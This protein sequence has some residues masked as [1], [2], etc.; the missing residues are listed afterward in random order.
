MRKKSSFSPAIAAALALVVVAS[1]VTLGSLASFAKGP[2]DPAT[3]CL[4][5]LEDSNGPAA[6]PTERPTGRARSSCGRA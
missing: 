5:T 6:A 2:N 3:E 1:L 4:I